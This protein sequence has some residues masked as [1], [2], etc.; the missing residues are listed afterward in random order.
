[1]LEQFGERV[2]LFRSA[3]DNMFRR[4]NH[5]TKFLKSSSKQ[6]IEQT[7]IKS[8]VLRRSRF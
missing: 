5:K 7:S 1:L 6:K 2:A 4:T 8:A 3:E